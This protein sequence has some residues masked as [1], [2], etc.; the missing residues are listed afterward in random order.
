MN[1]DVMVGRKEEKVR[2]RGRGGRMNNK[3]EFSF[4]SLSIRLSSHM[5]VHGGQPALQDIQALNH[6]ED[7]GRDTITD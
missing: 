3:A 5:G 1:E 4:V 2:V 7:L 6:P